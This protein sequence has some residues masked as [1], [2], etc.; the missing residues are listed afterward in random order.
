[1]AEAVVDGLALAACCEEF[2]NHFDRNGFDVPSF[3][4]ICGQA[5]FKISNRRW[6]RG[7]LLRIR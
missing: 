7:T 4:C 2:I 3:F 5:W 6:R 1:M